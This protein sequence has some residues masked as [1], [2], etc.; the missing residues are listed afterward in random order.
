M[1]AE[2]DPP[3][4][5]ERLRRSVETLYRF[6]DSR[7]LPAV[8]EACALMQ[9]DRLVRR[10]PAAA[11]KSLGLLRRT[12]PCFPDEVPGW[13]AVPAPDEDLPVWMRAD[14]TLYV[15]TGDADLLRYLGVALR[16]FD[17][18]TAEELHAYLRE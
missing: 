1:T 10:Y 18:M 12:R 11:R 8:S 15:A 5:D 6:I 17:R 13:Y 7:G 4:A 16:R 9:L 14:G 3:R 2:P